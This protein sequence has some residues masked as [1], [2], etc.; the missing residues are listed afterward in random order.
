M[1]HSGSRGL[2]HQ[3][4]TG[5]PRGRGTQTFACHAH[6]VGMMTGGGGFARRFARGHGEGDGARPHPGQRPPGKPNARAVA[7]YAAPSYA[8]A[9]LP[10][11]A[12]QLACARIH[13]EDGQNYLKGMAAAANFAWVNR[14]SMTFLCRQVLGR[15]AL[16]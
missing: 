9:L 10:C 8:R 15:L 13:S 16:G 3:V 5:K 6:C 12:G 11:G 14:S 4:A 1:I 2:G 7:S